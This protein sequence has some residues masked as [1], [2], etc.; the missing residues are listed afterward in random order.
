MNSSVSRLSHTWLPD[1]ITSTPAD[2][3]SLALSRV[4]PAPPAAFSPL[5]ITRSAPC[6]AAKALRCRRTRSRPGRPTMSPMKRSFIR[7]AG[8]RTFQPES[9]CPARAVPARAAARRGARRWRGAPAPPTH[10][11]PTA[12]A[13]RARS[14]RNR[15]RPDE[16][17]QGRAWRARAVPSPTTSTT[18]F[19]I[20]I[21]SASADTPGRSKT[22]STL[23]SVTKTSTTGMHSPATTCRRSGRRR[24]RSSNSRWTSWARWAGSSS[25]G[26]VENAAIP[27]ILAR[28]LP[29]CGEL[30]HTLKPLGFL[31]VLGI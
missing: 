31:R 5:A 15:A 8:W 6:D 10:R 23:R 26:L 2:R 17:S 3:I 14:G 18:P 27:S 11:T 4:M 12:R 30:V 20:R 24:A 1:V 7:P 29:G 13:R 28:Y 16:N 21:R 19:L 9:G 25:C 22:I